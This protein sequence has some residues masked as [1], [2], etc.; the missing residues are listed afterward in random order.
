MGTA[1]SLACYFEKS[2]SISGAGRDFHHSSSGSQP[3]ASVMVEMYIGPKAEPTSML[4][5]SLKTA[6]INFISPPA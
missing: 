2:G 1:I 5:N 4:S 6:V 3:A